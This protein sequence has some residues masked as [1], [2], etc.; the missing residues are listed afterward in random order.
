M[1]QEVL[2]LKAA[3]ITLKDVVNYN[4]QKYTKDV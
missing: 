1:L 2:S 4:T 3:N